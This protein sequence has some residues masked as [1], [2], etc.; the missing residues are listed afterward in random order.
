MRNASWFS[1]A[2]LILT[3]A[4]PPIGAQSS[5]RR[6]PQLPG[7]FTFPDERHR[8]DCPEEPRGA[9]PSTP[10]DTI[11]CWAPVT[12]SVPADSGWLRL[13]VEPESARVYVNGTY[14]GTAQQFT[15]PFRP[16]RVGLGPQ[17]IELRAPGHR[18]VMLW[19]AL[20]RNEL[21][22]IERTLSTK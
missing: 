18:P 8:S 14:V 5:G 21:S 15:R 3:I 4:A 10:D 11:G 2:V 17:R 13:D 20:Q 19:V 16:L 22:S 6:S 12:Y 1:L 7:Q 9:Q